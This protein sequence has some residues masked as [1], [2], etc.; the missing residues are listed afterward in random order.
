MNIRILKEKKSIFKVLSLVVIFSF[1]LIVKP[2]LA[3][4]AAT[5]TASTSN[6]SATSAPTID[7][8]IETTTSTEDTEYLRSV[9]KETFDSLLY[10]RH[11]VTGLY[12]Q[13]PQSNKEM[14]KCDHIGMVFGCIAIGG[15]IGLISDEEAKRELGKALSSLEKVPTA[16]GFP[17]EPIKAS[18]P[19]IGS[20]GWVAVADMGWYPCGLIVAG[21][22]YPEFKP[23]IMKLINAMDWTKMYNAEKGFL[24]GIY[25]VQNGVLK[26]EG[27][28]LLIASDQR[29]AIF[30][31]IASGKVPASVW[32]RMPRNYLTRYGEKYL[33]PGEGL[34]YGEQPWDMGYYIDERG[35]EVGMSN[36]NLAWVQMHY[37]LDMWYPTWGWSNCLTLERYMGFGDPDTSWSS[38]NAHAIAPAVVFYPNQVVKALKKLE[39]LGNR[40]PV[41]P[42]GITLKKFGFRAS[43]DVDKKKSPEAVLA[44]LDQPMIFMSLANYLYDGIIWKLFKQNEMVSNGLKLIK[45]YS[46]PNADYIKLYKS[47]DTKGPSIEYNPKEPG[48]KIIVVDDFTKNGNINSLGAN[49][50]PTL[51]RLNS[52]NGIGALEFIGIGSSRGWFIEKLNGVNLV[53][54]RLLKLSIKGKTEGKVK[55]SLRIG[56]TGGYRM[57]PITTE[58]TEYLIPLRSMLGGTGYDYSKENPE[59]PWTAMWYNRFSGEEIR[60]DQLEMPSF[61]LKEISFIA[62][63]PEEID[64]AAA[65]LVAV[66]PTVIEPDGTFDR[67][68]KIALWYAIRSGHNSKAEISSLPGV[69]GKGI[70]LNFQFLETGA[71]NWAL[72]GRKVAFEFPE[73]MDLVFNMKVTGGPA[74]LEVKFVDNSGANYRI[75]LPNKIVSSDWQIVR[76]PIDTIPYGWGGIAKPRITDAVE[77]HFAAVS[78]SMVSGTV[79]FDNLKIEKSK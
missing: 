44:G 27:L 7:K 56:G 62:A 67:M 15:K 9:L 28:D 73:K 36:A 29:M 43:Y 47:R 12:S 51:C 31:S 19:T 79:I 2:L 50:E 68:E 48:K 25:A 65:A 37:A 72:I 21:E 66:K 70:A 59:F 75:T 20:S 40:E 77:L 39:E 4:D 35:S 64:I 10:Y 57:L 53:H 38:I 5:N 55:L 24:K 22:A 8:I 42:D 26:A 76:V 6:D 41:R 17:A 52:T 63:T 49:R 30:I 54:H 1:T 34:G 46:N 33:K 32:D 18:D 13:N 61:E 14:S 45:E 23:R 78:K 74:D 16:S 58:W 3:E 11:P 69:E 71:D 60:I